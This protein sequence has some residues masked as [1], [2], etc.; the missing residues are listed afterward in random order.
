MAAK[1][2]PVPK[3]KKDPLPALKGISDKSCRTL[4]EHAGL[5]TIVIGKDSIISQANRAFL[6]LSGF[7]RQE[8]LGK[9]KWMEFAAPADIEKL[10]NHLSG[11][12]NKTGPEAEPYSF[13]F[14]DRKK[15]NHQVVLTTGKIPKTQRCI[16]SF[17]EITEGERFEDPFGYNH[18]QMSGVIYNIPEAT[19]AVDRRGSV[20]AWNRAI[21]ELTGVPGADLMGM[22]DHEYA[23]PF[24][25]NRRP[26]II[27]LIFASDTEIENQGYTGIQWTGNTLSA[28]TTA[29][30]TEGQ[31][32]IIREIASPIFNK[33]GKLAG[34]I[35]SITDITGLRD[36]ELALRVS[37][38]RYRTILE[39]T[40]S[41]I[42]IID[43]DEILSYINP[44][45]EKM[46]GYVRDEIEGKK[47]LTEF[48]VPEDLERFQKY[49]RECHVNPK[50][51][52]ANHEFQFIRFDGYVRTGYLTITPIPDTGKMVVSLLD[53]TNKIREEDALRRANT[54]LNSLNHITRHEILNH[55][56]VVKGYIELSREGI[57]DPPF[58]LTSLDK[59][60][61]A[62]NAIQNL[63]TFTRDYQ[64]IGI[65]PP[66]WY[67]L[68]KTIK[69]AA[70]SVRMESI[71][72]S[73]DI[74]GVEIYADHVFEKVFFY[75]I[76]D[77]VR[78]GKIRKIRFSCK[79]SFE[80]LRVICED[81]GIGI[82]PDKKEK[83]FTRQLFQNSGLDMYLS[84][85]ILSITG[86]SICETG[87][88]GK[89]ARFEI[90]IPEGA[91]RF[92]SPQ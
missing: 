55:L 87:T 17:M 48:V 72:L 64:N 37:E 40:A 38:S 8:I 4:F 34:A 23:I 57:R 16:F 58:L 21:E 36:L 15:R 41:A 91:Y 14:V 74:D 22:G 63:I 28:E 9:K 32:R 82:S 19:F 25:K 51:R 39:N 67:D 5:P 33:S 65:R 46:I 31:A 53:I 49:V 73:V 35:E 81:D 61:A 43:E 89:G 69:T 90:R 68:G 42:A 27:D 52:T 75:L 20:I 50:M 1:K 2:P 88:F 26:M 59:E 85:E 92:V 76:A 3:K 62:A 10:T 83:L 54:K 24:F 71:N 29:M 18:Q 86:I 6:E 45:F 44:E 66:A 78:S 77:A 84:R 60:L 70:A 80:E 13:V 47:K 7:R 79:E 11:K 12:T 30:V 56:T